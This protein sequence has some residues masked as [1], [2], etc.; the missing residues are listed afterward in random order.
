[1][2]Q[3]CPYIVKVDH[4]S[5]QDRYGNAVQWV[6]LWSTVPLD[7]RAMGYDAEQAAQVL[8]AA[9]HQKSV[10]PDAEVYVKNSTELTVQPA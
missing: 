4:H 7:P 3:D 2:L 8:A 1:M 9:R 5:D 10:R 6:V